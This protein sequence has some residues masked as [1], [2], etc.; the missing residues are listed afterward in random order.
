MLDNFLTRK[1]KITITSIMILNEHGIQGLTTRE[2][3]KRQKITEP[4]I[5]RHFSGKN[6][7][8]MSIIE[9]FNIFD[10]MISNTII[11]N[12]MTSIEALEYYVRSLS[13][14]YE[15]YPEITTLMF[16]MD[17]YR[18]DE[19]LN[20]AM[21][22]ILKRRDDLIAEV[23]RKGQEAKELDNSISSDS[24]S[25]I[26]IDMLW[27]TIKRWKLNDCKDNLTEIAMEKLRWIIRNKS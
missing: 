9:H 5:Y 10:E 23:V 2:I 16:S 25:N 27:G 13:G 26:I 4:A 19:K 3:A 1:E 11:E 15:N 7:I 12:E 8:I 22:E 18:Y 20:N 21:M 17:V 14:Y 24:L 6:E